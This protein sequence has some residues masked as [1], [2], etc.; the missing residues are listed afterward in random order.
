MSLSNSDLMSEIKELKRQLLEAQALN[1]AFERQAIISSSHAAIDTPLAETVR[2]QSTLEGQ[3]LIVQSLEAELASNASVSA[4][5]LTALQDSFAAKVQG[6][7]SAQQ[8]QLATLQKEAR[9]KE[10]VLEARICELTKR[11]EELRSQLAGLTKKKEAERERGESRA[12]A[13]SSASD[14][15]VAEWK[16]RAESAMSRVSDLK[17]E[18]ERER[19]RS[20]QAPPPPQHT[21]P[22]PSDHDQLIS[23]MEG[24]L[25][26]LSEIIRQR[27]LEVISLRQAVTLGLEERR[28]MT[29]EMS[30]LRAALEQSQQQQQTNGSSPSPG[31]DPSVAAFLNKPMRQGPISK[32]KF[33]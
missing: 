6:M 25:Q 24:Q 30:E 17:Q 8:E 9:E 31:L 16:E 14:S 7:R 22:S 11:E 18:L 10:E 4:Q 28:G 27:D 5:R 15:V 3:S 32:P 12:T 26:R 13:E 2:L 20:Q 1:S 29:R 21:L 23:M 33:K 19:L